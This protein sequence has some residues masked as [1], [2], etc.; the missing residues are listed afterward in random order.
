MIM[1]KITSLFVLFF[2][3]KSRNGTDILLCKYFGRRFKCRL[4]PRRHEVV[5]RIY[6]AL[7]EAVYRKGNRQKEN[8]L[9]LIFSYGRLSK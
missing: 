5:E 4:Q 8:S 3:P 7:F 9:L 2:A 6:T 1:I